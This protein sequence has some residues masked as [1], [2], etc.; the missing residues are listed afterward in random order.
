VVRNTKPARL[1]AKLGIKYSPL[2]E[3]LYQ[4]ATPIKWS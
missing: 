4:R 1:A 3:E 2:T